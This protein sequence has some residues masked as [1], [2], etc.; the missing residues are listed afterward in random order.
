ML[1]V[2]EKHGPKSSGKVC[3]AAF[4]Q[5]RIQIWFNRMMLPDTVLESKRW[6]VTSI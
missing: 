3:T 6:L 1:K 4:T 2:H 5:I